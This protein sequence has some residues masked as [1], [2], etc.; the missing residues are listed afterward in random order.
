M[1]SVRAFEPFLRELPVAYDAMA[2]GGVAPLGLDLGGARFTGEDPRIIAS[3]PEGFLSQ[4][5]I[6]MTAAE[7][8]K[9]RVL[10]LGAPSVAEIC[11]SL[12]SM[13]FKTVE[14]LNKLEEDFEG[15]RAFSEMDSF[16]Q[17]RP[18]F[19][20]QKT[21]GLYEEAH[22][23]SASN[24][25]GE[26]DASSAGHAVLELKRE[27][28][29]IAGWDSAVRSLTSTTTRGCLHVDAKELKAELE[30]LTERAL[31]RVKEQLLQRSS[32]VCRRLADI[33]QQRVSVFERRPQTLDDFARHKEDMARLQ[34]DD[35]RLMEDAQVV[36]EMHKLVTTY[37][38]RIPRE[39]EFL[40]AEMKSLLGRYQDAMIQGKGFVESRMRDMR[41][42]L[43]MRVFK[44][45]E[46][47]A[48]LKDSVN[49]GEFVDASQDTSDVLVKVQAAEDKLSS[50]ESRSG[51][52]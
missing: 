46:T 49:E 1:L 50:M 36:D 33:F 10:G 32:G 11:Y 13:R 27:M 26:G 30:P 15:A 48:Q 4:A 39:D 6:T 41:H 31:G 28:Q 38:G 17:V 45:K 37:R 7:D 40:A 14:V 52:F 29:K 47:M 35:T 2:F 21:Q 24:G 5:H 20:Y 22:A 25:G 23:S 3:L 19:D 18:A 44:L 12:P 9:S 51:Q 34:E 43:D 8:P 16:K 42:Q